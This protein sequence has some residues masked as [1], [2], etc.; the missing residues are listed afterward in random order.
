MFTGECVAIAIAA[1]R[2]G[3][4]AVCLHQFIQVERGNICSFITRNGSSKP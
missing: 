2:I 4:L 1:A 3:P